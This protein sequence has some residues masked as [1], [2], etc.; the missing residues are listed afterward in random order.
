MLVFF[1]NM[2]WY[3]GLRARTNQ[4][5]ALCFFQTA[6]IIIHFFIDILRFVVWVKIFTENQLFCVV[7]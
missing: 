5:E 1:I 2:T 7:Y 6:Q 4:I 3:F